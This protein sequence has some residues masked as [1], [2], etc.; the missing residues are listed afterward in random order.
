MK[1]TLKLKKI[2]SIGIPFVIVFFVMIFYV[3]VFSF[4]TSMCSISEPESKSIGDYIKAYSSAIDTRDTTDF[5]SLRLL[6]SDL[7]GK[8]VI[9]TGEMHAVGM[10]TELELYML[11]YLNQKQN[12]NYL[13]CET[14]FASGQLFNKYL[15]TGDESILKCIY[16]EL[17]GTAA[18]TME[19]YEF[20]VSLYNYNKTLPESKKIKVVGI[21]IEHQA[22]TAYKYLF[23]LLPQGS[24]HDR[25]KNY[26]MESLGNKDMKYTENLYTTMLAS[27]NEYKNYF[28]SSYFDFKLALGNLINADKYYVSGGTNEDFREACMLNN[29]KELY[30]HLPKGKYYGQFG[31]EHTYMRDHGGRFGTH[32]S[33]ATYISHKFQKT[34]GKVMSITYLYSNSYYSSTYN[35]YASEKIQEDN[36]LQNLDKISNSKLILLKFDGKDSPF[37]EKP[38]FVY[39]PINGVTTDYYQYGVLIKNSEAA[40]QY[41]K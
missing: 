7:S 12:V 21:D 14:G 17:K 13:L 25:M 35:N 39:D 33:F 15:D 8:E 29:F 36:Q 41:V 1:R 11:K 9:L 20:W 6:E 10:N 23:S 31:Q 18:G 38:Y 28:G 34:K 2:A 27:E 4:K 40:H 24:A 32:N 26:I 37:N 5:K 22:N 3:I 30:S 16:A 19:S